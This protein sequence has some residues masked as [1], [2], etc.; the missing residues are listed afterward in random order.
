MPTVQ[1]DDNRLMEISRFGNTL[2]IRKSSAPYQRRLTV[3]AFMLMLTC[4]VFAIAIT[5]SWER[6]QFRFFMVVLGFVVAVVTFRMYDIRNYAS[7][8]EVFRFDKDRDAVERDGKEIAPS[9]EVDHVLV[10]RIRKDDFEDPERSDYALVVAL[11]NSKRF[12]ITESDGIPGARTQIMRAA[13]ELA[14][15]LEV[16]VREGERL[17]T[18]EWLDR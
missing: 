8:D 18:E 9:S 7:K 1:T 11:Q 10:R 5:V 4:L 14:S 15:Y 6:P 17:P 12:T 13:E 3:V 2:V 16:P